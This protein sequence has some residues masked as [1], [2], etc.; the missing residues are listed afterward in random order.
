M[1]QKLVKKEPLTFDEEN[2]LLK[3][4]GDVFDNLLRKHY[5]LQGADY[6][7]KK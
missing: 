5:A 4:D 2:F 6:V 1:R 3:R 7:D